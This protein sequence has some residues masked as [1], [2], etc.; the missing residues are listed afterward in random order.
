VLDHVLQLR[1]LSLTHLELLAPLAQL[2][3]EVV[4]IVLG[5]CQLIL[6]MLQPCTSVVKEVSLDITAM[7]RPHQLIV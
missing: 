1:G 7:V 6:S 5:D 2:I 4:D 3:I